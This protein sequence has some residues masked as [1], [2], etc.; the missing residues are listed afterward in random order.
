LLKRFLIAAVTLVIGSR[1]APQVCDKGRPA[2]EA[3]DRVVIIG[4]WHA[5]GGE[6]SFL[7]ERIPNSTV[8]I[9]RKCLP[10]TAAATSLY[11][12]LKEK[13]IN[14]PA[15]YIG[16]SWGGLLIRKLAEDYPELKIKKMILIGTPNNGY[17]MA[18]RWLFSIPITE[19]SSQIPLFLVAGNKGVPRWYLRGPN[20]GT[21]EVASVLAANAKEYR[22]FTSDHVELIKSEK[23][24]QQIR[25]WIENN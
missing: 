8:I 16:H 12:Q 15:V 10:L 20:D 17:R 5:T 7:N 18:P 4:G 11:E 1:A 19:R 2:G 24:V 6:L 25:V 21:V 13:Q 14:G 23:V 9:P 22:I 3:D